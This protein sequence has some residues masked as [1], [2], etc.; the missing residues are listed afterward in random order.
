MS[1]PNAM[2]LHEN[3]AHA[4]ADDARI[5]SVIA[6]LKSKDANRNIRGIEAA[7]KI[8]KPMVPALI[9]MMLTTKDPYRAVAAGMLGSM[10]DTRAVEPL[11]RVAARMDPRDEATARRERRMLKVLDEAFQSIGP[12]AAPVLE[13]VLRTSPN[14]HMRVAVVGAACDIGEA[15]IPIVI[16]ASRDRDPRVRL[17]AVGQMAQM[18]DQASGRALLERVKDKDVGVAVAAVKALEA[19]VGGQ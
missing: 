10:K 3:V 11:L 17:L 2:P 5:A 13:R 4:Q 7:Y 16:S 12:A 1:F 15:G 6:D 8:R 14:W 18:G 9:E 19:R